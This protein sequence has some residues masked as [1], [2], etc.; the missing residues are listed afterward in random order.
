MRL[1]VVFHFL[2]K[3]LSSMVGSMKGILLEKLLGFSFII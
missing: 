3:I 2:N 1:F